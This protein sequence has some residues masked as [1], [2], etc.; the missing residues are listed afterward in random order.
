M[1][2]KSHA[3]A[4]LFL[5]TAEAFSNNS[6]AANE[7]IVAGPGGVD[8]TATDLKAEAQ[9]LPPENRKSA[10]GQPN[11]VGQLASNLYVRRALAAEAEKANLLADPIVAAAARIA[12]DRVLSDAMLARLDATNTPPDAALDKFALAKY[13]S[14]PAAFALPEEVNVRHILIKLTTANARAKA[15]TLLLQLKKGA[16][17][18]ALAKDNSDDAANAAKGGD[19][20][21]FARGRMVG[22]FENAAFALTK[23]AELSGV[24]ETEFGFHIIKLI[25]KKPAGVRPFAEVREQLRKESLEKLLNDGRGR[26][27]MRVLRD[28]KFDDAAI[29]AFAELPR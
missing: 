4:L 10:L 16:D 25:A 19:L 12:R 5:F 1:L 17:F 20:G 18:E 22:P 9:K 6:L 15:D 23:P 11:N 13:K 21:F 8:V 14:D 2:N 28:A 27:S 7:T 3:F 24:V 26:E 29:K